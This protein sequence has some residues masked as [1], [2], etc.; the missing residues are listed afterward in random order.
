MLRENTPTLTV[1]IPVFNEEECIQETIKRLEV[2]R[3]CMHDKAELEFL[4]VDDGSQDR[5]W[6]ILSELTIDSKHMKAVSFARNFGHQIAVSAGIDM[7]SGDYVAIMDAD[8]QDPPEVLQEMLALAMDGYD[9][10]YGIRRSRNGD[11]LFKKKSAELFYRAMSYL[12]EIDIPKDTG[13]FRI[14]SR[15]VVDV[16]KSMRERHRFIRGMIPWVGFKS[17]GYEYDRDIRFAGKT[18]YTLRKMF[19]F[20][21][22]SVLSFSLKPLALVTRLG[23]IVVLSGLFGAAYMLYLK[24]FTDVP[25]AG[26][27]ATILT[28]IIFGGVQ[29]LLIALVGEYVARIFDEAKGRPLYVIAEKRNI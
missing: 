27:T 6:Q 9:V 12:C 3:E 16:L 10:V 25:V 29:I 1:I 13:D 28:V 26:V 15:R 8:L 23:I 18:K 17:I 19:R 24:L 22:D 7:A 14:L 2:V 11:T 21:F 4:F 20:A 5:S